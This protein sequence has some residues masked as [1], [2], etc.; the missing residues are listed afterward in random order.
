MGIRS[1]RS[2]REPP[3]NGFI[4]RNRP[5]QPTPRNP[6]TSH[7]ARLCARSVPLIPVHGAWKN[8]MTTKIE[9]GTNTVSLQINEVPDGA[10]VEKAADTSSDTSGR[11]TG[12]GFLGR[13]LN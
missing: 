8:Y 3:G 1:P 2:F 7:V 9:P 5:S 4:S 10:A 11:G 12:F 6:P 13:H